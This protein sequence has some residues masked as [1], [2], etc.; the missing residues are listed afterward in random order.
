MLE[1]QDESD[2]QGRNPQI[3]QHQSALVIGNSI[4]D[5]S[6]YDDCVERN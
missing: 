1:V 2:S 5:F 3:I 4:D 6:I